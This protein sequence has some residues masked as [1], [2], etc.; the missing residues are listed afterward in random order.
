MVDSLL[1]AY[2]PLLTWVSLG[3]LLFRFIPAHFSTRLGRTL[4]WVGLP[5]QSLMFA[6]RTELGGE[7]GLIPLI[8]VEA[9]LLSLGLA[10][11]GWW[12][13]HE[14]NQRNP[15]ELSQDQP[16][17]VK[18]SR[19][20]SFILAA[21]MGN[22]GFIGMSL[23]NVL[24]DPLYLN[25]AILYNMSGT[26][27]YILAVFIASHFGRSGTQTYWWTP[28][29]DALLVPSL[30]AFVLGLATQDMKLPGLL[31][32]GLEAIVWVVF[33]SALLLVGLRLGS[34][35]GWSSFETALLPA[36]LRVLVVPGLVGLGTT[37][38]GL[39]GDPHLTMVLMSGAPTGLSTLI[40]SEV[41]D[42]DRELLISSIAMT[43]V[44][45]LLVLPLW[46]A[47]FS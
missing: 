32:S 38:I 3:V 37:Y 22:T 35:K 33:A 7:I 20:G 44:G 28:L 11:L 24:I 36:A 39:T 2:A 9:S 18:R 14:F 26:I 40:L 17:A 10:L 8:V 43:F 4:Y 45:L 5:I 15:R 25:W 12:G 34:I 31:E 21:M 29:R 47:W 23:A 27:P 42:L 30:W 19:L 41:Y 6:R 16:L 46:L 1:R 13:W